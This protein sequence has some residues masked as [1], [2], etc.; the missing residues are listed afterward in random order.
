MAVNVN[1][2]PSTPPIPSVTYK[3]GSSDVVRSNPPS[4]VTYY[5]QGTNP[6]GVSTSN[7]NPIYTVTS[8][9]T[10]YL[11][12]L[13]SMG[14]WGLSVSLSVSVETIPSVSIMGNVNLSELGD[15]VTLFASTSYDT[16]T[17][18]KDGIT[19]GNSSSYEARSAGDYTLTVSKASLNG[20]GLSAAVTVT[21]SS[22][23]DPGDENYIMSTTILTP[24]ITSGS[25]TDDQISILTSED[26]SVSIQYGDD[27]GRGVQSVSLEA[28]PNKDHIVQPIVYDG[29]GRQSTSYLPYAVTDNGGVFQSNPIGLNA[30]DYTNSPQ[31]MFYQNTN[32]GVAVD[33]QPYAVTVFESSPL[34]RVLKQG[35]PG[36]AWQ[37]VAG[38]TTDKVVR[39]SYRSNNTA[40][41]VNIY[42]VDV[43]GATPV[44]STEW[45]DAG[46]LRVVATQDE[47]GN[48]VIEFT[49]KLGRV[50]S[51]RVESG[52][53]SNPWAETYYIYDD[54][55]NLSV[56]LPPEAI[57]A[58]SEDDFSVVPQ[59]YT[60]A[61]TN[62]TVNSGNYTGGSYLYANGASVTID[63]GVT[64]DPGV[65]IIPYELSQ[66]ANE[67][68]LAQWAFQYNYDHRNR[69]VE[70]RVPGSGWVYMVYDKLDR[71]VATQDAEQRQN[72]QWTFTKY[73]AFSRPILTGF[74]TNS[75]TSQAAMQ[76]VVDSHTVYYESDGTSV[77]GYT[78]NAFPTTANA[79]DYLTAT[80]YDD[81]GNLPSDFNFSYT[82][83]LGNGANN[84]AVKGQ[85]VGSKT[86]ILGGTTWLKSVVYYDDRYRVLQTVADNHLGGV[87]RSTSKYDFAGRVLET[88]TTHEYGTAAADVEIAETFS[89]DHASRLLEATHQVDSDPA[90]IMVKNEYNHLGEL[91]DKKL[92]STDNGATFEQSVDYRYNIRGWLE[93]INDAD[94]SDNENDYFGMELA[95]NTTFSGISSTAMFNGNISAAK[96]SNI[97]SGGQMQ[98]AYAYSY[99]P[100]NRL[101]GADYAERE[102]VWAD[103]T[104]F[105][106]NTLSYDLNGN[107]KTLKRYEANT[108]LA[109]DDLSYTY[110]GN[111]LQAV[112]DAGDTTGFKDGNT[113]GFD[114]GYDDNGNMMNDANKD[115]TSITYNHLNLPEVVTFTGGRSITYTYDAA[116]IKLSK[117]T[118]DNGTIKV[119]DYS[120]GFIYEDDVLQQIASAEG[121]VRRKD[122]GD[123]VYDYYLKDHLG[124]S[125]V[126]FTTENE[127]VIYLATMES[128]VNGGLD[129]AAFEE[130][131]FL[132]LPAT[133]DSS[134]AAANNSAEPLINNNESA[135]LRGNDASR[136]IGPAKLMQVMPGDVVDMEAFGYHTGTYTDNGSISNVNVLSTIVSMVT[137]AAPTGAEGTAIQNAVN[138][139][140]GVI[141]V[142]GNGSSGAPRAYLNYILFDKDFNYLDAGFAQVSGTSNT[143]I[144]VN[145]SKAIAEKGYLYVYVSNESNTSFDVFFDDLRITH[146]KGKI[147]QE[148]HY[149]PFGLSINA[150][151]SRAPLSKPNKYNTFQGQE[152]T[153]DFDLG[154][155]QFKWRNHDPTIGRFFN[156]DPLAT[157][158]THNSPYAFSENR[159]INGVELEGLEWG[160]MTYGYNAAG[161][162]ANV[163]ATAMKSTRNPTEKKQDLAMQLDA[164]PVI[165]DV[166]GFVEAFTGSDLVS[167]ERLSG[168]SRAAGLLFLSELRPAGTL[169]DMTRMS[170]NLLGSGK[171][172]DAGESMSDAAA[173]FQKQ[174]T[175]VDAAKSFELN[176]VKFDG[177]ADGGVLL[178]AKSGMGNFV[179]KDGGFHSWWKG[180]DGLLNQANRQ[181]KAADG[182]KIQ[183]HFENKNVMQATQNLFKEQGIEGIELIHTPRN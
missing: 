160:G 165:G 82:Q 94:L 179:N 124:N 164:I 170:D 92:H 83:E 168:F 148:D 181:L 12:P 110:L 90:I 99:D 91:I 153:E 54:Y 115:I 103:K 119:T 174:I 127:Q 111:Q 67:S 154:W 131:L 18:K 22:D 75:A 51:K 71:L 180:S 163:Q 157:E 139:N 137:G 144:A 35:A 68:F 23:V 21:G 171:W 126:T 133:R 109:M 29:F 155:Y 32:N 44:T 129:Y 31:Y 52:D 41:S 150:L 79:T 159:V 36:A 105:D 72:D 56:V 62:I 77:L 134:I 64:L 25:T 98:S 89:Y 114:Y 63:P 172:I 33:A 61:N 8:S 102:S 57:R 50:V 158:Y 128:D 130:S 66:S 55:G 40:D 113:S 3:F 145:R 20:V 49:D 73:D 121:R 96:W 5:W 58:I 86:K 101:T 183:W 74:V 6:N 125:R 173:S 106:V 143:R 85:V 147:M 104:T 30:N 135:R 42:E 7:A 118:N 24:G 162:R 100:M 142:G 146:T 178:D 161:A 43:T 39:M 93:R 2:V 65:E 76:T 141:F 19:I 107:I 10:Y 46:E 48:E 88:K 122:N 16:Y 60:L 140:S 14:C 15:K 112:T 175:G 151:S 138:T 9:G 156:V 84:T 81:Y 132:N 37:P 152:R 17:W 87:D 69:M 38:S 120:G 34:N 45:Y 166:K 47:Q 27:L 1:E 28:S 80:Y 182:A 169:S 167:G 136:Q 4:G 13:N 95:Y 176:G 11:R 123:Y 26:R 97:A 177:L 70:K 108:T 116:G 149:Y 53:V 117:S 59:G 78:N